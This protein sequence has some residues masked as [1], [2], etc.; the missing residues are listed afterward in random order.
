ML[1]GYA[2][3]QKKRRQETPDQHVNHSTQSTNKPTSSKGAMDAV[4]SKYFLITV[5]VEDWFQV[6]NFKPWIPY[7][8]WKQREL[9]VERN[10]HK[11]LDIFDSVRR[12]SPGIS[13]DRGSSDACPPP[14]VRATFFTL[15]WIAERL[16]HL[17]REIQSRGHEIAS[18]TYHHNR[19]DHIPLHELNAELSQSKNLLEEITGREISGFRSPS[20]SVNSDVLQVIKNCGY[21]YDSSYNSFSLHGRYGKISLDGYKRIGIAYRLSRN[22]FELPISNLMIGTSLL[23]RLAGRVSIRKTKNE[24]SPKSVV[25]P[26][27]GGAYFRLI[28]FAFFKKGV[29][30]ILNSDNTYLFYL[31]PW[32]IDPDQPR[33]RVSSANHKLRHY[34]NIRRTKDKLIKFFDTFSA[35]RFITCSDYICRL[36]LSAAGS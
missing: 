22:F 26:W 15:G 36:N 12:R 28:P 10:V 21:H 30:N 35:H 11:L 29:E 31:H 33:V 5:D 13:A 34:S 3:H 23:R 16:P 18:H 20:F 17:V 2:S 8:T 24:I 32:E 4:E 25:L 9:R 14:V 1:N 6:E 19:C 27:G 7:S